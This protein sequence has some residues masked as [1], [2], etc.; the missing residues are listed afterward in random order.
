MNIEEL[1]EQVA[2]VVF[3]TDWSRGDDCRINDQYCR[4]CGH[5]GVCEINGQHISKIK[6]CPYDWSVA[7]KKAKRI[8]SHPNLYFKIEKPLPE[9]D[10]DIHIW[11]DYSPDMAYDKCKDDML[12]WVK[13]S[14]IPTG[15]TK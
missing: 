14:Y 4:W 12:Q 11:R 7:L 15:E 1:K 5:D 3:T 10:M 2:K 9:P 13:E 6:R 8:L